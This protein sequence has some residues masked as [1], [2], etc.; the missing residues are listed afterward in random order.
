ML[1]NQAVEEDGEGGEADVVQRQIGGVV[2]RLQGDRDNREDIGHLNLKASSQRLTLATCRQRSKL[3]MLL[4]Y[5]LFLFVVVKHVA[6]IC[7]IRNGAENAS[8]HSQLWQ[9]NNWRF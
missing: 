6:R 7:L 8:F 4:N 5:R 1:L 2:Q 9:L 3:N